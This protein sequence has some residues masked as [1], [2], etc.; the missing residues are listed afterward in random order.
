ML[1]HCLCTL[2]W[3]VLDGDTS[4]VPSLWVQCCE[5]KNW[6]V[7]PSGIVR[8]ISVGAK[9]KELNSRVTKEHLEILWAQHFKSSQSS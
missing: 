1:L 4:C 5:C 7:S 8:S 9:A 6:C 3:L 2:V